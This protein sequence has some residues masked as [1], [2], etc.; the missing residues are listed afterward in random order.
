[1]KGKFTPYFSDENGYSYSRELAIVSRNWFTGFIAKTKT[2]EDGTPETT[3]RYQ[4]MYN[5][6]YAECWEKISANTAKIEQ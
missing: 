4:Q 3:D 1:M 5:D 6:I 2:C